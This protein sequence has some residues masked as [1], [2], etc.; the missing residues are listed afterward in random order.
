M[1]FR[2]DAATGFPLN[3]SWGQFLA[4]YHCSHY[5]SLTELMSSCMCHFPFYF[6]CLKLM[7][8]SKFY[9]FV[10]LFQFSSDKLLC[11]DCGCMDIYR[12]ILYYIILYV[13]INCISCFVFRWQ[14]E[15]QP[16]L[17][18]TEVL[19]TTNTYMSTK[20]S[21]TELKLLRPVSDCFVWPWP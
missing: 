17:A 11:P 5:I 2:I 21:W 7:E 1:L 9:V 19:K 14:D 13:I 8:E 20:K 4:N 3:N 18:D 10:L 6:L 12:C 16:T 15:L